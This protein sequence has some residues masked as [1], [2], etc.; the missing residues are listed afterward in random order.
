ME[1]QV[2]LILVLA[3]PFMLLPVA[4]IWYINVG[5]AV[6]WFKDRAKAKAEEDKRAKFAEDYPH[7]VK[8]VK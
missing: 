8:Y 4:L 5:G 2:I 7:L 1:W 3:A 6:A